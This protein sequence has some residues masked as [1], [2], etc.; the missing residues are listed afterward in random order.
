MNVTV[1]R[2]APNWPAMVKFA[3]KANVSSET[4]HSAPSVVSSE[5]VCFPLPAAHTKAEVL[6][7][8]FPKKNAAVARQ[9]TKCQTLYVNFHS[10]VESQR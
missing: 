10:C 1:K 2:N 5:R 6:D 7:D 9:C 8:S 3:K 4:D